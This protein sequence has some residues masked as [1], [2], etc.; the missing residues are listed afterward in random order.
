M[1]PTEF[2]FWIDSAITDSDSGAL[3]D[4]VRIEIQ[5]HHVPGVIV[6]TQVSYELRF[7]YGFGAVQDMHFEISGISA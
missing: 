4:D 3:H 7:G 1:I 5:V 6:R 2:S